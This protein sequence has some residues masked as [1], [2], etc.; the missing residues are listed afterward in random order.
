[1]FVCVGVHLRSTALISLFLTAFPLC[2]SCV[3]PPRHPPAKSKPP[4]SLF[5]SDDTYSRLWEIELHPSISILLSFHI[6]SLCHICFIL[7]SISLYKIH[8]L[9]LSWLCY[10]Y[11]L[12]HPP[13]FLRISFRD[14]RRRYSFLAS[15]LLIIIFVYFFPLPTTSLYPADIF[16]SQN[17]WIT[18]NFSSKIFYIHL[19][20][21]SI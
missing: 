11:A 7:L 21:S 19:K 13:F 5:D 12:G 8:L 18:D 17:N 15:F 3:S 6:E 10:S 2:H 1:M 14:I 16:S 9:S 4:F 20:K